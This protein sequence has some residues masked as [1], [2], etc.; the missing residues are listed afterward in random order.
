MYYKIK[1]NVNF[2]QNISKKPSMKHNLFRP[3]KITP[4]AG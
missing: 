1:Y 3:E 4:Q 2:S